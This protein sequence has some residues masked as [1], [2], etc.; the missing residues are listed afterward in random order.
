VLIECDGF[1][2]ALGRAPSARLRSGEE[3]DLCIR[4]Q[5]ER[6]EACFYFEPRAV[7]WHHVP[8]ARQTLGYFLSRCYAEGLSKALI[9]RR[10]GGTGALTAELR[11]AALDLPRGVARAVCRSLTG[12]VNELTTALAIVGGFLV[13]VSGYVTGRLD[14]QHREHAR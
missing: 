1:A 5:R 11:Y 6:P 13:T 14:P 12:R 3:T 9:A 7:I 8:P 2:A 4:I 10:S